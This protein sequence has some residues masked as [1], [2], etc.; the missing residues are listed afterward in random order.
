MADTKPKT[1]RGPETALLRA[2]A[3]AQAAE[4][5]GRIEARHA[6]VLERR[7]KAL[8]ETIASASS[9]EIRKAVRDKKQLQRLD[10]VMQSARDRLTTVKKR[11]S[12]GHG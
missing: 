8:E 4:I 7:Q 10:A 1:P 11:R 5:V 9:D 12:A 2:Q 6:E 3:A